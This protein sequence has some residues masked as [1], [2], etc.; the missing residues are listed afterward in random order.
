M[1][2]TRSTC[3]ALLL[4][5]ATGLPA[6]AGPAIAPEW[7]PEDGT[8]P[9]VGL[10][11]TLDPVTGVFTPA[12][13]DGAAAAARVTFKEIEITFIV[14]VKLTLASADFVR[15]DAR[16]VYYYFSVNGTG[17]AITNPMHSS[18]VDTSGSVTAQKL[19]VR[20]GKD[21]PETTQQLTTFRVTVPARFR[22]ASTGM[23]LNPRIY[24]QVNSPDNVSHGV[25]IRL[26]SAPATAT[27]YK[28]TIAVSL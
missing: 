2:F 22:V 3:T 1:T 12:T 21:E 26:P 28:K 15:G 24:L 27:T 16:N 4:A 7:S 5:L 17:K 14:D 6:V 19:T 10:P 13:A 20:A 23:V 11:G 9:P 25:T 8:P 18:S